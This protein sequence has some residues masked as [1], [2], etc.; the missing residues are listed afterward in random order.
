VLDEADRLLDTGNQEA[1]QKLHKKILVKSV[2]ALP[3]LMPRLLP[4]SW[5]A[6]GL[7]VFGVR[8]HQAGR[9]LQTLLFSATLHDPIIQTLSQQIQVSSPDA[10]HGPR[11]L[12]EHSQL[13]AEI[14]DLG[15]PEGE[16]CGAGDGT[17][18]SAA[19]GSQSRQAM[20]EAGQAAHH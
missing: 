18:R 4:H 7:S 12:G 8:V 5:M 16:G 19:G 17:P 14:P 20:D 9:R 3:L 13:R 6:H 10:I 2:R 15:G 11:G 1:I